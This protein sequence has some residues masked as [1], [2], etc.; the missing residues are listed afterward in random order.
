M[1]KTERLIEKILKEFEHHIPPSGFVVKCFYSPEK[2]DIWFSTPITRNSYPITK[3]IELFEIESISEWYTKSIYDANDVYEY[4]YGYG[5][6]NKEKLEA[7]INSDE[8]GTALKSLYLDEMEEWIELDVSYEIA[9]KI[10]TAR[11]I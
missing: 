10:E 9:K 3:D 2:D 7:F 4:W 8:F 1:K 5:S 6:L 11:K